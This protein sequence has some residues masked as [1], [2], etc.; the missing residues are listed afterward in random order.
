MSQTSGNFPAL[1]DN[2]R[3]KP[4]PLPLHKVIAPPKA[5]KPQKKGK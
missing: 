4:K 2:Q 3:R 5:P 1:Y